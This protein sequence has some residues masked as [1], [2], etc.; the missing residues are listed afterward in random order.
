MKTPQP[1]RNPI[2]I[3]ASLALLAIS[4]VTVA[5]TAQALPQP[6]YFLGYVHTENAWAECSALGRSMGFTYG[7]AAP[8]QY[9][10]AYACYGMR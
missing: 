6:R 7:F 1:F 4:S 8:T 3:R 10:N 2:I 5:A 9:S